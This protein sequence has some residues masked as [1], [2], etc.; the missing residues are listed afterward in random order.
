MK[1]SKRTRGSEWRKWDLHI[2]TPGTKINDQ[3]AKK[4]D[5]S[6]DWERFC[7]IIHQ[8]DVS[9][10]G[11]TDYYS[12]DNFF[13]FKE[14]YRKL[15]PDDN[16]KVFFPN[17]ELRLNIAVH[18]GGQ[19]VNIHLI[20]PPNLDKETAH[21]LLS[22][23]KLEQTDNS[24][25][26]K[27]S[28]IEI[29][30]RSKEN[31]E[32]ASVTTESIRQAL[33]N[34]FDGLTIANIE[35]NAIIVCSGRNDG[36]SPGKELNPRKTLQ[37]DEIKK[38]C[39]GV[40]SRSR[41]AEYWLA[42]DDPTDKPRPTFGGCDAHDFESLEKMLG[43]SGEDKDRK[44]EL[45]WIKADV[46]FA[47]LQQTL[48]EP[49]SRVRIQ[50]MKPDSKQ[51]F[52]TIDYIEFAST[53]GFPERI[54]FNPNLNAIIGSRSSG[55]STLLTHIAYCINPEETIK[56][57]NETNGRGKTTK[58]QGPADGHS[59]ESIE[60]IERNVVWNSGSNNGGQVIFVPQNALFKLGD[61]PTAVVEKI[62]PLLKDHFPDEHSK[63]VEYTDYNNHHRSLIQKD[64]TR[65]F[66]LRGE[67]CKLKASLKELGEKSAILAEKRRLTN[68]YNNA[69]DVA[70]LDTAEASKLSA[71]NE[72]MDM[73]SR[74]VN[75][76]KLEIHETQNIL[77]SNEG[78]EIQVKVTSTS[79][80]EKIP[81][82]LS[83][84]IESC[85]EEIQNVAQEKVNRIIHTWFTH[86]KDDITRN[87]LE[88]NAL[89]E[90][91][92]SL[93]ERS[94]VAKSAKQIKEKINPLN[95]LLEEISILESKVKVATESLLTI[96]QK[97]RTDIFNRQ[98]K[99]KL[100]TEVFRDKNIE[101]AGSLLFMEH[102]Y[103]EELLEGLTEI[104]RKV[105]KHD[106]I[107]PDHSFSGETPYFNLELALKQPEHFLSQLYDERVKTKNGKR[108]I[109]AAI[110]ILG[111]S[112]ELRI[113]ARFDGDNIGGFN[114]TS[115]TPGKRALFALSLILERE[116]DPWPLLLDQ[117][118]DDLDSRSIFNSIV[119]FLMRVKEKRQ[120]ILVS[121]DANLVV[122][123]D[124][125]E[126]I[127][128]NRHGSDRQN[129][130]SS[131]FFDY[132]TGSLE[133]SAEADENISFILERQGIR[134]HCCDILDGG[135]EAFAKRQS[136]YKIS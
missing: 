60:E 35:K 71:L 118:E 120:V 5:G 128:A 61:D 31:F 56:L 47:G 82:P 20:L 89:R 66:E 113:S 33:I 44:W 117:P 4:P 41:D 8:S 114:R 100:L 127:V 11:I 45:T 57:Q 21:K 91:N 84:E 109:E 52:H 28:A 51:P 97:L 40:F 110:E 85:L 107:S 6:L 126:V 46:S 119:P 48:L 81:T 104:I 17:L 64:V 39:H 80:I 42:T 92:K 12:L 111:S 76:A 135:S 134:Q 10:I 106:Y 130:D 27:I 131:L 43:N 15:Y 54:C 22:E 105:P 49:R 73:I 136:K 67:L 133:N 116:S 65:W 70:G 87:L 16:S 23:L 68:E 86:R 29:A 96:E 99:A 14:A 55:K 72:Q 101:V 108:P 90:E 62:L 24:G 78:N 74:K 32:S 18:T 94:E 26:R 132:L 25:T 38:V 77:A 102:G 2:H 63:F 58:D 59:W 83:K 69:M 1:R 103:S 88:Q 50:E 36:L 53:S 13:E 112:P 34:T 125:E 129:V 124:A 122:G 95:A 37:I 121:H 9:G 7:K 75:S 123:A 93:F 115:M 30:N 79:A 3:Y 19:E 98:H